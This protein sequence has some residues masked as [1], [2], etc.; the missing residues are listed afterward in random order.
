MT[1]IIGDSS[2]IMHSEDQKRGISLGLAISKGGVAAHGGENRAEN[3]EEGGAR[4]TFWLYAE[5]ME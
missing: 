5:R 1:G 3:R 2:L 4:F